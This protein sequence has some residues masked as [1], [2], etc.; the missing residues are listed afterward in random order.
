MNSRDTALGSGP[1]I[2]E[3]WTLAFRSFSVRFH[4]LGLCP[5]IAYAT[6]LPRPPS[7]SSC[8]SFKL[9]INQ[10]LVPPSVPRMT[11]SSP[12]N[13]DISEK[14]YPQKNPVVNV[15][16]LEKMHSLSRSSTSSSSESFE[17]KNMRY[18]A[19][20]VRSRSPPRSSP[21]P[22][23]S[24]TSSK[25][26]KPK[27]RAQSTT[28]SDCGRHSNQWLFGNVSITDSVKSLFEK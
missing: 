5:T 6:N 23:S 2:K 25:T 28:F 14:D 21:K 15:K 10:P 3:H 12:N 13:N 19:E 18:S 8:R 27:A 24:S 17:M 11:N 20:S 16:A 7:L 4:R 22:S 26:A 9:L 1:S